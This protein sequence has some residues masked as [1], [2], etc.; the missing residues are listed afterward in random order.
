M[1]AMNR[2]ATVDE[3]RSTPAVAPPIDIRIADP[4]P[5]P[6]TSPAGVGDLDPGVHAVLPLHRA[7]GAG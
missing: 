2:S 1:V 3:L 6:R 4:P 5:S 7:V